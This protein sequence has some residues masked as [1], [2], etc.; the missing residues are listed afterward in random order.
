MSGKVDLYTLVRKSWEHARDVSGLTTRQIQKRV[1]RRHD[2]L[3]CLNCLSHG[4]E[5]E[6][7]NGNG[8]CFN[9]IY[10]NS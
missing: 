10:N 2:G 3:E 4:F 1:G 7:G 8:K 6:Y 9:C 5:K